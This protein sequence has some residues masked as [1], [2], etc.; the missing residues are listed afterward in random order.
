LACEPP[1]LSGRP[2]D[3][4]TL[5]ELRDE[6]IKRQ[7]VEAISV[8]QVGRFLQQAAVQPHRK[9]MWLNTTEKDP[10]KFQAEVE[11]VCRTYLEAPA[12]EAAD[13]THTV[14][15]DEATSLQAIERNAPDQPVEP[16]G[17]AKQEFEYTRHGTTTLTAG[18]DV[19]TG[20]IVC[21]TLEATRTEPEFVAHIARTV[22][23]DPAADWIFV[24]D[25]LNTHMSE[26]LVQFVAER[27][28]L[29]DALG[30]KARVAS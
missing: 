27:C 21:P 9:K 13:G 30:K 3:H 11:N 4:W 18:L 29:P 10:Q 23:T 24:V 7:I 16:G 12:K 20:L 5:R 15:V 6:A 2:I 8:A 22:D 26:S 28:G 17:V 1:K 19:V 14:S 25:C